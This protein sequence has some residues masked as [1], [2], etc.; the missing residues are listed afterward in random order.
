MSCKYSFFGERNP[1][2]YV[3]IREGWSLAIT[4]AKTEV[5]KVCMILERQ[6]N[7]NSVCTVSAKAR[8]KSSSPDRLINLFWQK[9]SWASVY[10]IAKWSWQNY[11]CVC[12]LCAVTSGLDWRRATRRH[13]A[14]RRLWNTL[15]ANPQMVE[16][17][18]EICGATA[19]FLTW[20]SVFFSFYYF[21][22]LHNIPHFKCCE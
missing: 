16:H 9:L 21:P 11:E 3:C 13:V 14:H 19:V 2:L 8:K 17:G 6:L 12:V 4:R 7:N 22:H 18:A 5:K 15:Q 20:F 1:K 10:F